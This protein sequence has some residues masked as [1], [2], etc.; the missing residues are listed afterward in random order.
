MVD[1]YYGV[2]PAFREALEDFPQLEVDTFTDPLS[3]FRANAYDLSIIDIR[4]HQLD[5]FT[6]S[7]RVKEIYSTARVCFMTAYNINIKALRA[8]F[9]KSSD[10]EGFFIRKTNSFTGFYRSNE[11]RSGSS[12]KPKSRTLWREPFDQLFQLFCKGMIRI[13]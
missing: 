7:D 12:M 5:K 3:M 1:D 9:Q 8:V 4:L 6:L 11:I 2:L 10:L 13:F